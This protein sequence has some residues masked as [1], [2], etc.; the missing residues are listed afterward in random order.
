[1]TVTSVP[2]I[3]PKIKLAELAAKVLLP[4]VVIDS[5]DSA[6]EDGKESLDCVC[7]NEPSIF[8]ARIFAFTVLYNIVGSKLLSDGF[9][10]LEVIRH[11]AGL[12]PDVFA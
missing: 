3:V 7:V 11:Q 8:P 10:G 5:H 2:R 6:L 4:N 1:L 9:V 12:I